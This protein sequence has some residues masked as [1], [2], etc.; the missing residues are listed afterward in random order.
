MPA[1]WLLASATDG[2]QGRMALSQKAEASGS[3]PAMQHEVLKIDGLSDLVR[4]AQ[5]NHKS[6]CLILILV[7]STLVGL[8]GICFLDSCHLFFFSFI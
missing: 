8:C 1:A 4:V 6:T 5:Y 3:S 2:L 7:Y